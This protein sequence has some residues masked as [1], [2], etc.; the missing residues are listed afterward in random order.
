MTPTV[1]SSKIPC[2]H[3]AAPASPDG[4][5]FVHSHDDPLQVS[6]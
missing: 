6:E 1:A 3:C 5:V 4:V 2:P